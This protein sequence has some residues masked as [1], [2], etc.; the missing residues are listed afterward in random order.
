MKPSLLLIV[1]IIALI[2]L[3]VIADSQTHKAAVSRGSYIV[4]RVAMCADC[5]TPVRSNRQPDQSRRLSGAR[6]SFKPTKR[7]PEWASIA[8]NLTPAGLLAKWSDKQLVKFIMTGIGPTGHRADPPM[9]QYRL[10]EADAKA[11]TAYLRSLKRV[12]SP[13]IHMHGHEDHDHH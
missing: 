1:A 3:A 4:N 12:K 2:T 8:I 10:N 6:I 11:V 13:Y 5:H 7:V 9:P